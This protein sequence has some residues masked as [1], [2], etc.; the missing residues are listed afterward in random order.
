MLRAGQCEDGGLER[1]RRESL[2][3]LQQQIELT[4]NGEQASA[5]EAH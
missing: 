2:A 3:P 1:A 5:R 4:W